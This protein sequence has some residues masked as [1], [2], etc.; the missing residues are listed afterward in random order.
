MEINNFCGFCD[1]AFST[2]LDAYQ[3]TDWD[4]NWKEFILKA[5]A[6]FVKKVEMWQFENVDGD[7]EEE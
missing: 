2:L 1:D 7:E 5:G 6:E 3:M 4:M